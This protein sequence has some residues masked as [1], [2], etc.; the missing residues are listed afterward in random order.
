M[1]TAS[2]F[3]ILA[4]IQFGVP[5]KFFERTSAHGVLNTHCVSWHQPSTCHGNDDKALW[6][7][8]F[9]GKDLLWWLEV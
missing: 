6:L 8:I 5:F 9:P 2:A 3:S 1:M 4:Y 7:A